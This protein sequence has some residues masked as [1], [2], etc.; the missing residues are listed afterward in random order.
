MTYCADDFRRRLPPGLDDFAEI[1]A[2]LRCERPD[3]CGR[4]AAIVIG[5]LDIWA[6]R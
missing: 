6:E 2:R 4:K 3:G 5:W 1:Q